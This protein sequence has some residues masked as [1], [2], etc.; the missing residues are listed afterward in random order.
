MEFHFHRHFRLRPKMKSAFRSA[1][2]IHHKRSWSWKNFIVLVLVLKLR[3]WSWFWSW[4]KVLIT[5]LFYR[6]FAYQIGNGAVDCR[7]SQYIDIAPIVK[8]PLNW[9]WCAWS[10]EGYLKQWLPN[11]KLFLLSH[12]MPWSALLTAV[13]NYNK[14]L[15]KL[16]DFF[17][18]DQDQMFKTKTKTSWS[19][20][21]TFIF[22]LEV[23]RDQDPGL[24]DYITVTKEHIPVTL[25]CLLHWAWETWMAES[26]PDVSSHAFGMRLGHSG[27]TSCFYDYACHM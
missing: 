19:K 21:K 14:S 22:V 3:S 16:Q 26:L 27:C 20:T 5:W 11:G 6:R 12:K 9:G 18:Q 10:T 4:K 8:Y 17:L 1:S 7:C 23:P 25:Q 15:E 24:E 2:S 13:R